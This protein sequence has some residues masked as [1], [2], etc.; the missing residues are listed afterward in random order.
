MGDL[1]TCW[2][3]CLLLLLDSNL[4]NCQIAASSSVGGLVCV[5]TLFAAST[6]VLLLV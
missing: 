6:V 1:A 2:L 5:A 4:V 3:A